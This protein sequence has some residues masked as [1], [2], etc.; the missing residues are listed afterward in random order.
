MRLA[1]VIERPGEAVRSLRWAGARLS[2]HLAS[3]HVRDTK[4]AAAAAPM[5]SGA[6]RFLS[7]AF[8]MTSRET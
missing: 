2:A 8:S 1:D 7:S 4:S 5:K 3:F 6:Y